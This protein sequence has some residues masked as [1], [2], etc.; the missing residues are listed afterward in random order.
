MVVG[1]KEG[2]QGGDTEFTGRS[3]DAVV[4]RRFLGI[5]PVCPAPFRQASAIPVIHLDQAVIFPCILISSL[6][7]YVQFIVYSVWTNGACVQGCAGLSEFHRGCLSCTY[8][9]QVCAAV[10]W[11]DPVRSLV[12]RLHVSSQAHR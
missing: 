1:G 2:K 12:Q 5:L 7:L 10:L 9:R 6:S 8:H 3:P 4:T 11:G